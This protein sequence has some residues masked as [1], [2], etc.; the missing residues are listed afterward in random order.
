M[1]YLTL[2][3]GMKSRLKLFNL[4]GELKSYRPAIDWTIFDNSL[5]SWGYRSHCY[6]A[7]NTNSTVKYS[8]FIKF[9]K[10]M[11]I[12]FGIS[13]IIQLDYIKFV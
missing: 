6:R 9:S 10:N 3:T 13:L 11:E 2:V 5:A 12:I 8:L 1:R 7:Y 4:T